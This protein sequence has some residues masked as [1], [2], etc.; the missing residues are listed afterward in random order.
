MGEPLK[1]LERAEWIA[2]VKKDADKAL[3]LRKGFFAEIKQVG[4]E[5]ERTLDFVIS[6]DGEDRDGDTI[7]VDGWDFS[8]YRK[9]PVVLFAHDYSSPAVAR[10]EPRIEDG[11][12]KSRTV[13]AS[14]DQYAFAE[15]LYQLYKGG[16]MRATSVGFMPKRWEERDKWAYDFKEQELLEYSL[17]PVPAN[18]RAVLEAAQKGIEVQPLV[19]WANEVY[20][21]IG[22]DLLGLRDDW[23]GRK[24]A[25]GELETRLLRVEESLQELTRALEGQASDI[26]KQIA[27]EWQQLATD[28]HVEPML[29]SGFIDALEDIEAKLTTETIDTAKMI[30]EA[31]SEELYKYQV[32]SGRGV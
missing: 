23:P 14:A 20:R 29:P 17:V 1:L 31:I 7:A 26:A 21:A 8:S 32:N 28:V 30:A 16:F 9:N 10:G 5:E 3:P 19:N 4:E 15:T 24:G 22:K 11:K 6:D 25:I 2:Q 13:F 18:P 12:V 27:Q